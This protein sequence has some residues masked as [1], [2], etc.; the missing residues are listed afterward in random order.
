M[1]VY[2]MCVFVLVHVKGRRMVGLAY[3]SNF[4]HQTKQDAFTP[5]EEALTEANKRAVRIYN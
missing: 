4:T 2:D 3:L 5:L 1:Y